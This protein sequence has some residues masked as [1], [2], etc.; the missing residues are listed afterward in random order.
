MTRAA[1]FFEETF[2]LWKRRKDEMNKEVG[3]GLENVFERRR[4]RKWR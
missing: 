4:R 1:G 3:I 2:I